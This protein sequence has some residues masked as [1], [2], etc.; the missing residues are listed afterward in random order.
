MVSTPAL[1]FALRVCT[2]LF[3]AFRGVV[4][5]RLQQQT[6]HARHGGRMRH[7]GGE[8]L[9]NNFQSSVNKLTN[10]NFYQ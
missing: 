1:V 9:T 4:H 8:I 7:R 5:G 2:G 10:A 6:L 3:I